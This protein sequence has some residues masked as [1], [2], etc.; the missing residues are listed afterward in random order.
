MSHRSW[1]RL[2]SCTWSYHRISAARFCRFIRRMTAFCSTAMLC[3]CSDTS[4]DQCEK[5]AANA[6]FLNRRIALVSFAF[7]SSISNTFSF[8]PRNAARS[9]E[10]WK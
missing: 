9:A 7:V 6:L 8:Q 2:I 5:D 3:L 10:F 1:I 4:V